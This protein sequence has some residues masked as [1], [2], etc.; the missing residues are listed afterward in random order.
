MTAKLNCIF[1]RNP[2]SGFASS[3]NRTCAYV[4]DETCVDTSTTHVNLGHYCANLCDRHAALVT[5]QHKAEVMNEI[6][7]EASVSAGQS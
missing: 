5:K 2:A 7:V 3:H 1:K 4:R 6:Y